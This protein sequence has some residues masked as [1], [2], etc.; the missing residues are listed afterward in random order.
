MFT[1]SIGALALLV[2]SCSAPA[3]DLASAIARAGNAPSDTAR[4]LALDAL[5]AHPDLTAPQR[6]ERAGFHH[7]QLLKANPPTLR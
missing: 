4:L 3:S 7:N 1:R 6:E 5:A 2:L